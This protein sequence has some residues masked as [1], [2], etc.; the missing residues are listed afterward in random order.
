[1]ELSD[2][3]VSP[4]ESD[5]TAQ[6]S[7]RTS[8]RAFSEFQIN[9]SEMPVTIMSASAPWAINH[10]VS[11][12]GLEP[13]GVAGFSISS[14][15]PSAD[16]KTSE[17]QTIK[18]IIDTD[19]TLSFADVSA[20][21]D[22]A[23]LLVGGA[24]QSAY[25]T[26]VGIDIEKSLLGW[27]RFSEPAEEALDLSSWGHAGAL[28]GNAEPGEGWFGSGINLDGDGS[29]ISF[30]DIEI[31]ENA[32][33]TIEGWFRFHSFAMDE[34]Q[35]MGLF[36]GFYQH[37]D[38]NHLYF[39]GTNEN[40]RAAYLLS[41][42]AWHHIALSWDGDTVSA[43]LYIDGQAVPVSIQGD[44]ENIDAIDG[45]NIGR[46][47]GYFGGLIGSV[48]NTFDGDVDEIRVWSR[49]LSAA[50]IKASYR[51]GQERQEFRIE[52]PAGANADWAVIGANGADQYVI[53]RP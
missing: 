17:V 21:V 16:P 18:G 41:R 11:L 28:K 4:V 9:E 19:P 29:F 3:S 53:Q 14:S 22:G 31:K 47:S 50:E 25:R 51:G 33:A 24:V 8:A 35:S 44:A 27:W 23:D 7:W 1:V 39:S 38:N 37:G 20:S 26:S 52:N 49:V 10:T 40:F 15:I 48:K 36:S 30:P 34:L 45:L 46:S 5:G 12:A 43:K 32:K 42:N 6:V 13:G 2:V